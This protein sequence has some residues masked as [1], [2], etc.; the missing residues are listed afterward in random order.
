MTPTKR[1]IAFID[2]NLDDLTTLLAGLRPQVEPILLS[3]DEPAARQ[4]AA[5]VQYQTDLTAIHVIAHGKPGEVSFGSGALAVETLE[6]DW[7]DLAAIGN[8]LGSDGDLLLWSC[9]TGEGERG[10]A[11]IEEVARA[12]GVQVIAATSLVGAAALGGSWALHS[13]R[14][15]RSPLTIEGM[16]TY[17]GVLSVKKASLI[18]IATDTG[19]VGDF[20]TDD[21]TL[22]LSGTDKDSGSSTLGIWISGGV[23]GSLN[24]GKG[25]LIGTVTL[26]PGQTGWSFDFSGTKLADGTYTISLTDGTSSGGSSLSSQAITVDTLA[27]TVSSI[28]TSGPG[29]INGSGNLNANHVVTLTVNFSEKVTVNTSG[30]IPALVLN[31]G[32]IATY[33]GGSGT[34]ALTF[35][36][37]IA[38]GQN[39]SDLTVSFFSLNGATVQDIAG[40]IANLT[41]A[42]NF[43]PVGTL[44]IDTTA[45]PAPTGLLLDS[46]TDSGAKGDGITNFTQVKIDGTAEP[47]STVTLYDTNGTTVIGTG[48]SDATTGAFGITTST[49]SNGTHSITAKATDA[50]G[51]TGVASAAYSLT[52]MSTAPPAPTGLSLDTTTDSGAK[53]DGITNFVQVKIDGAAAAGSTVTLY[54]T[55]GTTVLGTGTADTTTG[56]FS[57]TTSTLSNGTHSITAKATDGTGNTSAASAA[58]AVTVDTAAPAAPTGLSLDNTT[59]SGTLGDGITNFVQVKI[60]GT[61]EAGSTV[62]L[63]DTDGTT[64]LGT[65]TADATAGAFSITTS[66]LSSGTYGI[67]AK[68]MDVAGNT[69]AASAA[70]AVTVDTTAPPA[71]TGLS[72]DSTTDSGTLGDGIT[73][74]AQV[75]IDG[76]AEPGST[77]TLYDTNGT[78]VIGTGASDATTGAFGITTSTLSNGTHSIT[79]KATDAAG[80]T[81]AASTAYAVTVMSI[82]APTGLSLD[83][84]TDSGAKGDGITNFVQVKIDGAAAAGSTVTLYDTDGTTVIGTGTADATTGAFSITTST[85]SNGTHNITAKATDGTGNTSAASAAYS[86]TVDTAAPAAPTGLSLDSTTDSGAKGDGITNFTQLNI[87]GTAEAGST[88]T[89]YDTDGTTVLGSGI[90]NTTTGAF[91]ITTSALANGTHSITAKATDA[92]GNTGVAS[93]A[94]SV[95]VDTIA[96]A[97]PTGLSL[98]ST[99]DSGAKG[100][101]ITNFTQLKIDGTAEAGSTVTL[102]DTNG[103]TVLGS[104][105]ANATTG[106]FSITTSALVNGAHSITAKATDAAGNTGVASTAYSVTVDTIAPAAPTGCHWTARRTAARR[107]TAS[108]ILRK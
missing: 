83:T 90:A 47:G 93:T 84:T 11:F 18:G 44:I 86:V 53:G 85:L 54:D 36:Y 77:V 50:A 72:L 60:D 48:A 31:D 89:L 65:G 20:I 32:G 25:T 13:A 105:I 73:S 27:P 87:D 94:Y 100:D 14:D 108:P 9:R 88:V 59:D 78:T 74:F 23:Y 58:Y 39:T 8:A 12:T 5:A 22:V 49:L 107:A 19:T 63:Y 81:G 45:P 75:K 1:E 30:G 17:S 99:T 70:Y 80:N 37:T 24:G 35:S 79:A 38:A 4:M 51:N 33:T 106:A 16:A 10:A 64:V 68:A 103:T 21:N 96:P 66:G 40:N 41:G 43:N 28:A 61:A 52:V 46:A 42:N 34:S 101:G 76:T 91:S 98:D 15:V 92:A 57:I 26:S 7:E 67:T 95:T 3:D 29:I 97:A 6:K 56:A 69:G 82:A 2:R 62:T 104:G 71:P 55:D 102:Y